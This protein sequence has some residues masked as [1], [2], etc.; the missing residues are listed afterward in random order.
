MRLLQNPLLRPLEAGRS[1]GF[2]KSL[3]LFMNKEKPNASAIGRRI[4]TL[5]RQ[6][7]LTQSELAGMVGIRTGPLNTLERGHHLPSVPVLCK[8]AQVLHTDVSHL[9]D[10]AVHSYVV[11]E[12]PAPYGTD[13]CRNEQPL[14]AAA[15]AY[16]AVQA[17]II[18][19]EPDTAHLSEK[20]IRIIDG[21]IN[22]FLALEDIVEVQKQAAIPLTLKL[23]A[24]QGGW[25]RFTARVRGL[26]GISDAVIFDY[27]G[28]FENAGLRVVFLPLPANVESVACYDR[29][30]ENA[31]FLIAEGITV[32]R[33]LFRLCY[34]LGRIY[35]YNGGLAAQAKIGGLDTEH[36]A[37]RFA[38]F[39]L[40]PEE[41]VSTSVRQVGVGPGQCTWEL[42]LRLKHRFGV[43]AEAFLY[44]L[45]E[46][47]LITPASL[48]ELKVR[49]HAHYAATGNSEP[50]ASRRL[51]TPNGRLGDLLLVATQ[52][53]AAAGEL[54]QIRADLEKAGVKT[55]NRRN[56]MS[57]SGTK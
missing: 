35:L 38:A 22:A 17:R 16:S 21:V 47:D 56:E 49:I 8:L 42:L 37:R 20:T 48:K 54:K 28:L 57:P 4:K 23:P 45:G 25:Q 46:L 33:Q 41:A 19:F 5:R 32:E 7:N 1:K 50:D 6:H 11:R 10:D 27:L 40:M 9:L 12:P 3:R 36:A 55:Q 31:F 51:L 18:R 13:A 53:A 43:S 39:F 26:L 2:C 52:K 24:T 29:Q 30:C 14:T 34:E 44:R 15:H